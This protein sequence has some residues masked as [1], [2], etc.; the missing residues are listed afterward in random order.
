M[1]H[2]GQRPRRRSR[3][4]V[5]ILAAPTSAASEMLRNVATAC[6]AEGLKTEI[7]VPAIGAF[8]EDVATRYED[9]NVPINVIA[10]RRVTSPGWG[11]PRPVALL[12]LLPG[13]LRTLDDISP[14]CV[15]THLDSGDIWRAIHWWAQRREVPGIV[16]QEGMA[17]E[18]KGDADDLEKEWPRSARY[19][20]QMSVLRAVL[21]GLY[22]FAS[23]NMYADHVCVWGRAMERFLVQ[24][25]RDPT[26]ITVTGNPRYDDIRQR[27]PLSDRKLAT[28]LFA[29]QH[30]PR[31][32]KEIQFCR[33][34]IDVCANKIGCRLLFRPHPRSELWGRKSYDLVSEVVGTRRGVT[35]ADQG[36]LQDYLPEASVFLTFYSGAAYDAVLQGVP[37]VLSDWCSSRYRFAAA[38]YGAAVDVESPSELEG[39]LRQALFNDDVRQRLYRAGDSL[40][41]DH[42]CALDGKAS[43]RVAGAI[44]SR[45]RGETRQGTS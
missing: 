6:V 21:P 14:R 30:Q 5:A 22:R 28:V 2:S 20:A 11:Y 24:L 17:P 27:S 41:E 40:V 42:L 26:T 13:F 35:I 34:L 23:L 43:L 33:E 38:R 19:R 7:L 10:L 12:T 9:L 15:V 31:P 8:Y 1:T 4:D 36:E 18:L 29:H 25:G 32:E 37:L 3:P 16:V 39:V 45:L 44:V